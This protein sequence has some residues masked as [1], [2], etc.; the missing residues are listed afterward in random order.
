MRVPSKNKD[1]PIKFY[2]TY[3]QITGELYDA[4]FRYA[5]LPSCLSQKA[6]SFI[7]AMDMV[8]VFELLKTLHYPS[9]D[10]N[11]YISIAFECTLGYVKW[12]RCQFKKQFDKGEIQRIIK[13][14][15][16]RTESPNESER[17]LLNSLYDF[18]KALKDLTPIDPTG[19]EIFQRNQ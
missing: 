8:R 10:I 17:N 13:E 6:G 1:I 4:G 16:I 7:R 19:L 2:A 9:R 3:K 18:K 5:H 14:Y 12:Q 15:S 11:K